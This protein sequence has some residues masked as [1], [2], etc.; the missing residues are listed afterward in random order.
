MQEIL[1]IINMV[2]IIGATAISTITLFTTRSLQRSQQKATIMANKRS[3]RIDLMREY[4]AGLIS[5]G[6]QFVYGIE[7][8]E[9]KKDL[10][11]FADKFNSLLQYAYL[12]DVELIDCANEIVALCMEKG[13]KDELKSKLYNF[14]KMCDVYVGVEYERLKIESM[15]DIN[16]SGKVNS[17]TKT[18]EDIYGILLE[19][20]NEYTSLEK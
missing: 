13:S 20:Q 5:A 6:K 16:G 10:I 2:G 11:S 4:S 17:E 8:E 1:E 15:G 3:E 12:R 14:W 18:F 7:S 9:T 19:K